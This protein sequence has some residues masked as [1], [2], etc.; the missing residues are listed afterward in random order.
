MNRKFVLICLITLY[1]L[2][3]CQSENSRLEINPKEFFFPLDSVLPFVYLYQEQ[4]NPLDEKIFRMYQLELNSD[5]SYFVLEKYNSI[6]EI[7]EGFTFETK[8]SIKIIDHMVV[9]GNQMKR[10]SKVLNSN[11]FPYDYHSQSKFTTSFPGIADSSI[12]LQESSSKIIN[13]DT[14]YSLFNK[15][16]P[17]IIISDSTILYEVDSKNKL[18]NYH[19]VA[20]KRI[21]AK[22][23]GLVEWG[24]FDNRILYKLVQIKDNDWWNSISEN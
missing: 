6:F 12:L 13:R 18:V 7:T 5:T 4:S 24:T 3:A 16:I 2:I 19:E 22:H 9:D 14:S 23:I 1:S 20:I 21:Y 17:A 15:R 8:D 10:K 11:F